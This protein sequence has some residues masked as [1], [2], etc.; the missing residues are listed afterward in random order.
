LVAVVAVNV[1]E[2]TITPP[3]ARRFATVPPVTDCEIVTCAS[4][5]EASR[6]R[7]INRLVIFF[8]VLVQ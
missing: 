2:S 8:I 3:V 5:V 4:A 7:P 1:I 6:N